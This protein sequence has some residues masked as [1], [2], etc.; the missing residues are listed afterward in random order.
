ME[1]LPVEVRRFSLCFLARLN[2][3]GGGSKPPPPFSRNRIIVAIWALGEKRQR[4]LRGMG[5]GCFVG[6]VV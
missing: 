6:K 3:K 2:A 4:G 5:G 1:R